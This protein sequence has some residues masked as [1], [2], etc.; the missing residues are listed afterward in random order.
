MS[1]KTIFE[2]EWVFIDSWSFLYEYQKNLYA[3]LRVPNSFFIYQRERIQKFLYIWVPSVQLQVLYIRANLT[4]FISW[5]NTTGSKNQLIY[6]KSTNG[7]SW[8]NWNY[9]RDLRNLQS[10]LHICSK[11]SIGK[12]DYSKELYTDYIREYQNVIYIQF[13]KCVP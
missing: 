12:Y 7:Y 2:Y 4:N 5:N 11:Y 13:Y 9:L 1:T 10:I 8:Y 3:L 6:K